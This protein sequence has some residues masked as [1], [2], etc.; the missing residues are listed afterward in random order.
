[1]SL[2]LSFP[3]FFSL[4][5]SIYVRD[6]AKE[7]KKFAA[8]VNAFYQYLQLYIS[9]FCIKNIRLYILG[10]SF[11]IIK[12]NNLHKLNYLKIDALPHSI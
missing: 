8:Y 12:S 5:C 9:H 3:F 7:M 11:S 2:N 6:V 1:M 10:C 4:G